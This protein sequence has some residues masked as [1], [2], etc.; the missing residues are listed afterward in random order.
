MKP[1]LFVWVSWYTES[2][3]RVGVRIFREDE[4]EPLESNFLCA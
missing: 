3:L 4:Y 1:P 2:N